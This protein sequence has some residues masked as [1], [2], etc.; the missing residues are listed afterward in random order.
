MSHDLP[1]TTLRVGN[2]AVL[3]Q[4]GADRWRFP[5][6]TASLAVLAGRRPIALRLEGPQGVVVLEMSRT[7]FWRLTAEFHER[8]IT[9]DAPGPKP[10]ANHRVQSP[11]FVREMDGQLHAYA[12]VL[13]NGT[14]ASIVS[15]I[16]GGGGR[17]A[18][19]QPPGRGGS[20]SP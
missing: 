11:L 19:G 18:L 10:R 5:V 12:A 3:L 8:S 9:A 7:A 6:D 1:G 16:Q 17:T 20:L 4:R 2:A 13:I 15:D 14:A